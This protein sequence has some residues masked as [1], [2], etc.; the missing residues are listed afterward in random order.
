MAEDDI[1]AF[2]RRY[3]DAWADTDTEAFVALFTPDAIYRDDQV[4][5]FSRG[6]GDLRAFHAHFVAAISDIRMDFPNVFRSGN[7]ACLEWIFSGRQTGIYHGRPP[8]GIAFTGKGV[9]VMRFADDGRILSVTDYYDGG[10]VH[11]QLSA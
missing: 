1:A 8:T 5:R 3:G 10:G 2:A 7:D 11:R 4:A 6:H 9:A